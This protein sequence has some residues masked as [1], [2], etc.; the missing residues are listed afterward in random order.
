MARPV[1]AAR[2]GGLAEVVADGETGLLV[3]REDP[4]ALAG[5]IEHLLNNPEIARA[6]GRAGRQRAL[7]RFGFDRF[8]DAY[9]HLYQKLAEGAG[10]AKPTGERD[11][12]GL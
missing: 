7:G 6:M 11:H 1:I 4:T 5:G 3:P 8:V 9:E 10:D 2:A 12:P